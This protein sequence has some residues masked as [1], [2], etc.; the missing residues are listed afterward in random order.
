MAL[1]APHLFFS[2]EIIGE[3]YACFGPYNKKFHHHV[4]SFSYC[5]I[6][7]LKYSD[8]APGRTNEGPSFCD[9]SI[10]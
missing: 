3:A 7:F 9:V 4:A 1:L 6:Q 8:I 2:M 10:C 5:I